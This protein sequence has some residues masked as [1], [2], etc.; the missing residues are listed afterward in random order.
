M[1]YRHVV[2]FNFLC[3]CGS[4]AALQMLLMDE[5]DRPKLTHRLIKSGLEA[6]SFDLLRTNYA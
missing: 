5:L 3:L 2:I 1:R 4:A 6:E